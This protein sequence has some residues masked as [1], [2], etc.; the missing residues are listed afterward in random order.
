MLKVILLILNIIIIIF[1][2]AMCFK[3]LLKG[4]QKIKNEKIHCEN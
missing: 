4:K 1:F 2:N 3:I